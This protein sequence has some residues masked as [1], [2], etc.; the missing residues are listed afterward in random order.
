MS[1]FRP[2]WLIWLVAWQPWIQFVFIGLVIGLLVT[3]YYDIEIE[4]PVLVLIGLLALGG[5]L[6]GFLALWSASLGM[7][8]LVGYCLWRWLPEEVEGG[9]ARGKL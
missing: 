2:E 9:N 5:W 6:V 7:L 4:I 3:A 1:D 8:C